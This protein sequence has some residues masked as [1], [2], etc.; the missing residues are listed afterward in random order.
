MNYRG[1]LGSSF[2]TNDNEK[3]KNNTKIYKRIH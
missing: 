2:K 1:I 3:N